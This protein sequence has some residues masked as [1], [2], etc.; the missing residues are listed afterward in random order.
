MDKED[1]QKIPDQAEEFCPGAEL[2]KNMND[3]II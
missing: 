2:K 1:H 3:F